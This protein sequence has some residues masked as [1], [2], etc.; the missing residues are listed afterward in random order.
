MG[1]LQNRTEWIKLR[2]SPAE[3]ALIQERAGGEGKVGGYL[4]KLGLGGEAVA[5]QA[6][7]PQ[8]GE[9]SE[10]DDFERR[11][12]AK[13]LLMPRRAAETVVRREVAAEAARAALANGS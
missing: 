8:G 10:G 3:K 11:I 5:V 13:E 1:T 2:V 6:T 9:I 12:R 7:R 4:R